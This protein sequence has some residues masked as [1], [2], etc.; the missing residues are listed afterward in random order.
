[1]S[2]FFAAEICGAGSTEVVSV[3]RRPSATERTS[4]VGGV[5]FVSKRVSTREPSSAT[6]PRMGS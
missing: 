6:R 4:V 1:M 3:T 2:S 5:D